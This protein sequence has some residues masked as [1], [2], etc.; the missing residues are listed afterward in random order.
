MS[1]ISSTSTSPVSSP[2]HNFWLTG[3]GG[4]ILGALTVIIVLALAR[5][6]AHEP[7]PPLPDAPTAEAP[8]EALPTNP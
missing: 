2:H 5:R 7:S 1:R 3:V 4:F 6:T 8:A